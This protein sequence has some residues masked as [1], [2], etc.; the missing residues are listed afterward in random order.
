[1]LTAYMVSALHS[2]HCGVIES[3]LCNLVQHKQ[4]L[5][6]MHKVSDKQGERGTAMVEFSSSQEFTGQYQ[7]GQT[8]GYT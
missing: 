8:G 7:T 3:E 1:M 2:L 6:K 5:L 4:T